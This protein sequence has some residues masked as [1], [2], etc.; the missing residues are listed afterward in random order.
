MLHR[1]LAVLFGLA[2]L[3]SP[4]HAA[5]PAGQTLLANPGLELDA[6][7]D[8]WPDGWPQAGPT[9][10]W[11]AEGDNHFL[12]LRSSEPGSTVMLYREVGIPDGVQALELT[13]KQRVTGLKK[14][15]NSWFDARIMLEFM[16]EARQKVAPTPRA[17]STGKDTDGWIERSTSFIVPEGAKTLKFMPAL[18]QVAEGTFDLDD[19]VLRSTDPEP[20]RKQMA[21]A[22]RIHQEKL[23]AER[24]ARQAKA[25]ALLEAQGSL[26][27]HGD[28]QTADRKDSASPAHWGRV[29]PGMTWE[30]EGDNR[31]LRMRT[32]TP[33]EMIL[34]YRT[35]DIPAGVQALELSWKQRVTGLK[36]GEKPWFDARILLEIHD[37]AGRKIATPSPAYTQKDTDGWVE[38]TRAF[39]VPP[40]SMTLVL[41]PT[42]FQAAAGT[43]DIDDVKIVPTEAAPLLAAQEKREA[44]ARARYVPPEAPDRAKWPSMLKVVGNRVVDAEGNEVLLRGVNAG[45]LET[46]PMDEQ[47]VKSVVVAIEDWKANCVRV[48]I[49]DEFWYGQSAYQNDGGREYREKIDRIITLAAN[50]GAYVM[51]DLHRYRAPRKEHAVFWAEFAALYKNHPAVLFDVFNEPHGVSWELWRNGGFISTAKGVDES[52]FL[53][54]EERRRNQ[55]YESIGMQGLVD[56]VRGAGASNIIVAGGIQ[57]C[58][59]LS[60]IADGYALDDRGG[61][62]IIYSWHCYNWHRGWEA[63]VLAVAEK[64]PVVVG[65][66]GADVKKMGF[67]PDA[68]QEDPHTWAPDM[69]GFIQKHKLHWTAWC[70][71]TAATPRLLADWDYT[72]T[73]FWGAY[74]NDALAGKRFELK[75]PR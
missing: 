28:F 47:P 35:V 61:N 51:I 4:M 74:V 67:I 20:I 10:T 52:A 53:S 21:E 7:G 63:K 36:K 8:H 23:A 37:V 71:H 12:R 48:P 27:T 26:I 43:F 50:R 72:P 60:G 30:Q 68:D 17:P 58:N 39:V 54:D 25:Q 29:K 40:G 46:L 18:L 14:G 2:L 3:S 55:G 24:Q 9:V 65:E 59:D 57:W 73:P 22:A 1:L 31:F 19:I 32:I 16:N 56:A 34:A 33:G 69:L 13:W 70:M 75:R 5:P 41:M 15:K 45:G 62:G 11:E 38:K 49:K 44:Q 6:D 66:F 64:H 42:L